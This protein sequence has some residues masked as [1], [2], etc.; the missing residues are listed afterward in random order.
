MK[1]GLYY[2]DNQVNGRRRSGDLRRAPCAKDAHGRVGRL[3][4]A[5][6]RKGRVCPLGNARFCPSTGPEIPQAETLERHSVQIGDQTR[7]CPLYQRDH[8]QIRARPG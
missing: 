1:S 4:G 8:R 3:L 2:G 6:V 7:F 5:W